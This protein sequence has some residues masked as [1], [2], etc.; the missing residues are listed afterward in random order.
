MDLKPLFREDERLV[1]NTHRP[2]FNEFLNS[3]KQF[4]KKKT[5]YIDWQLVIN[6]ME[7]YIRSI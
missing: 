6:N 7:G 5:V 1:D 3:M 4:K 2:S